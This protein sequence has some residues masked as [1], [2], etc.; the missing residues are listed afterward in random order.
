VSVTTRREL[1]R[2][3]IAVLAIS[4]VIL[5]FRANAEDKGPVVFAAASLKDALDALN[6]DWQRKAASRP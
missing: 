3:L 6:T 2:V 4:V 1:L 5:P